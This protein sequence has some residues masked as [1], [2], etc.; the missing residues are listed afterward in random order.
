MKYFTYILRNARRNPVRSMLTD[1][2]DRICLFLMMILLS[3]FAIS[4]EANARRASSTAIMSLN[5]NGFAGMLPIS[6]VKEIA[7]LDGV[8]RRVAV[9]LVRRQ[10]SGRDPAVCPVRGRSRPVFT[11]LDEFTIPPDQLKAFQENKDGCVIGRKLADGQEA[12]GG[13]YAAAQGR[14]LSRGPEPDDPRHLRRPGNRDLRMCL[15]R[16]DY[17]DEALKRVAIRPCSSLDAREHRASRATPGMIFIK[18]KTADAMAPLVQEDR[19]HVPEQR[20]PDAHPDRGSL[21]Q[22]VRGDARR[23]ERNDLRII[24]LAVVVSLLCVAGNSMAMAM[25]ERTERGG[26]AQGDRLQSAAGAVHGPDRGRPGRR[27]RGCDRRLGLARPCCDFVDLSQYTA[28]FLPFFYVP[29]NIALQ[30][31]AV[32][33]LIGL[34]SGL[35]PACGPPICRSSTDCRRVI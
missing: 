16:C 31:L 33:L 7:Q 20:L 4:D 35:F 15:F 17:F 12:Q 13:R 22:D 34:L 19:R 26:R 21:R 3:F 9:L 2:L 25:R 18:C 30:G 27:R 23:L 6:R 24:G 10:V 29:W 32:S 28:G 8:R 1:R 5:A 11:V 14:C